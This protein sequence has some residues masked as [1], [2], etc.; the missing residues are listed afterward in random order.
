MGQ[1]NT[2]NPTYY[3]ENKEGNRGNLLHL[4]HTP[5]R[6][7]KTSNYTR[8]YDLSSSVRNASE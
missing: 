7:Y 4:R 3:E 1:L 6:I 5:D 8:L 2:Y